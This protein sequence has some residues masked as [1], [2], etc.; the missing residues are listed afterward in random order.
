VIC[1]SASNARD[2]ATFFGL[3]QEGG[4]RHQDNGDFK[5]SPPSAQVVPPP[6]TGPMAQV[7]VKFTAREF[8]TTKLY[9]E[10]GCQR[11]T[12]EAM[13]K[14]AAQYTADHANQ[15]CTPSNSGTNSIII[16]CK[17]PKPDVPALLNDL[18]P[19]CTGVHGSI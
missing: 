12:E 14:V 2:S 16:Y 5:P 6:P 3:D 4:C 13:S 18:V 7:I 11:I 10:K 19:L 8:G 15:S 17:A 1:Y 9:G